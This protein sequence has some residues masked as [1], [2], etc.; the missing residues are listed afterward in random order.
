MTQDTAGGTEFM[1]TIARAMD[2]ASVRKVFGEPIVRDD[3]TIIPVARV[4][5][6]GGGGGGT[7][8]GRPAKAGEPETTGSGS[9]GGLGL[10]AKPAGVYVVKGG[11][12]TWRP[13]VDVNKI[14]IGGQIVGVVALL[15]IRALARARRGKPAEA[16]GQWRATA[17]EAVRRWRANPTE[18]VRRWRANPAEAVGRWR[19]KAAEAAGRSQATPAEATGRCRGCR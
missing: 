11:K 15:V 12:V 7:G 5:G 16:R 4:G 6:G 1:A 19:G 10:T 8:T 13:A 14:I 2:E 3:L 9:G 17:A 18:T